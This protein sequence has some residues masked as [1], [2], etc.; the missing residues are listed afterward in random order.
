MIRTAVVELSTIPGFAYKQKLP[1]GGA[2]I[3]ILRVD[4][5]QP[6]IAGISKTSGEAIPTENT[7]VSLFP[8]D[9]FN[10]AIELTKGLPY[11]KQ[12]AVK[13]VLEQPADAPEVVEEDQ[14]KELTIV[15]SEDYQA[16]VKYYTD[17]TGR[18]SYDLLN[19]DLI[20]FA[21]RSSVVRQMASAKDSI[22]KICLYITGT[23]FRN[24]SKNNKLTDDQIL[25]ISSLL[26]DIYPRGVFRE[27][28]LEL[29]KMISKG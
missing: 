3:V 20:R 24:I 7:Q 15:D 14:P 5:K 16:I 2:G 10:E 25:T 6:G 9:A 21:H 11:K 13:L 29:R 1:S 8:I 23:K 17:G 27:L 26:D 18:F 4:A 12:P 28:N 19:K 22:D